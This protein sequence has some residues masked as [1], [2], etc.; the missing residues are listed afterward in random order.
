M[1]DTLTSRESE[2]LGKDKAEVM[3]LL[4]APVKQR[5]WTNVQ[6]PDDMTASELAAFQAEQ[7][8]E[9]WIYQ[10][11]RVHFS[12]AGTAA[13]VDDNVSKD[14]PPEQRGSMIA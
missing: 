9:I 3:E 1:P 10:T 12:L 6:T 11:G 2:I 7:L 8:D 13:L 5:F 14:L 4:G